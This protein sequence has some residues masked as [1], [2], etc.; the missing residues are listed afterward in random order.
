MKQTTLQ[1]GLEI[2]PGLMTWTTFVFPIVFAFIWP[3]LV[4]IVVM[5]YALYWFLRMIVLS[6]HLILGYIHYKQARQRHWMEELQ[7]RF[8][9]RWE[10]VFHLVFV[11]MY[12]EDLATLESTFDALLASDYPLKHIGVILCTEERAGE[13]AQTVGAAIRQKYASKFKEFFIAVHPANTPGEV[14][15][16]GANISYA[17]HEVVPQLLKKGYSAENILVTTLDSDNRV[18]KNYFACVTQAFLSS[19]EPKYCS[20]QPLPMY[21]N[22]IWD[23][24][25]YI[26]MIALGSSFWVMVEATR[27]DRLRN[28]SAHSQSLTGL[29]AC[30][31]WSVTSIV[32]DGHQYWRSLYTFKGKHNV[33]PI[34]VPIYQDAVL[35]HSF[36]GTVK[37]Q[38]L[39]KRRWAWGVSDIPYVFRHNL[40]DRT[41]SW[42]D[43]W[44]QFWRLVEG[45][46]FWATTS[47]V[48]ALASWPPLLI[49][50][51]YQQTVFAYNFPF[52]YSKLLLL[53]GIGMVVSLVIS[54]LILP[55]PP[56][57]YKNRHWIVIR[58]WLLTPILLPITNIFLGALPAV[59]AQTRLMFGK[60]LEF[61]V[62]VKRNPPGQS[63]SSAPKKLRPLASGGKK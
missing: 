46:Y 25:V 30:D 39:Q 37:E 10:D 2:L 43:K 26:R 31:Y 42:G 41:M 13:H 23:V 17:A 4:S 44:T 50:V 56:E 40:N 63:N 6:Y 36:W 52:F 48:L 18:D 61:R 32:E 1:R 27:P 3:K 7:Y 15:G 47:F 55:P 58:D 24:P 22:N 62:T 11:P 33:I 38:Y 35:S 34:F 21:F 20:Y 5:I 16:K 60:H 8:P 53:A 45:H 57:R 19:P 14:K 9:T 54:T 51:R 59:D 49:N 29:I 12:K 28:F